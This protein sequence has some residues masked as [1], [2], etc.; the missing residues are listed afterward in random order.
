MTKRDLFFLLPIP[1]V[2]IAYILIPFTNDV[3]IFQGVA[4]L[5]DY[6]GSFP[7]SLDAA[8]EMKPLGNRLIH[9]LLY[10]MVT[11]LT[12]FGSPLYPVLV[13]AVC[14]VVALV[15]CWYFATSFTKERVPIF[16]I[17][18]LA[19]LTA[20]NFVVMQA[21]W[22]A[23]LACLVCIGMLNRDNLG[24]YTVSGFLMFFMFLLKGI[25]GL[26]IIPILCYLYIV[27]ENPYVFFERTAYAFLGFLMAGAAFLA[28]CLTVFPHAI[29]DMMMS[30]ALARVGQYPVTTYLNSMF[31]G[32]GTLSMYV[33]AF[34]FTVAI[35]LYV[36]VTVRLS[37]LKFAALLLMWLVPFLMV[38]AQGEFFLYHYF[39]LIFPGILSV[40]YLATSEPGDL[41][42][43]YSL[44]LIPMLALWLIFNSPVGIVT[45]DEV[46]FYAGEMPNADEANRL[47]NISDQAEVL[48]LD[49][50][51]SVYFFSPNTSCRYSAPLPVQRHTAQ[52]NLTGLPAYQEEYT[53]I[54]N[55]SGRFVVG[56]DWWLGRDLPERREIYEKFDRGY[57]KVWNKS[58]DIYQRRL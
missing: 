41:R 40:V 38:L 55:Y 48:F 28:M 36:L 39:V 49:P 22:F 43:L 7:S 50:G 16:A 8:W 10:K 1:I 31:A 44:V 54:M 53:C 30:A 58:W 33:P 24:A 23:V 13:K 52:W 29:P 27:T 34:V 11:P 42:V 32:M 35:G 19:L 3:R 26:L 20:T 56:L 14:V 12:D 45:K 6:Y 9:Y 17:S 51:A 4:R 2:A 57:V 21:E 15:C 47:F 25:S 5:V 18:S 37:K 46:A